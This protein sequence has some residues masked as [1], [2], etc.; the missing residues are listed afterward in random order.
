[1]GQWGCRACCS[2]VDTGHVLQREDSGLVKRCMEYEYN[3]VPHNVLMV[4]AVCRCV[5]VVGSWMVAC[6][7]CQSRTLTVEWVSREWCQSCKAK[8]PTT[9]L[10]CLLHSSC[11]YRRCM[12]HPLCFLSHL[13]VYT[14]LNV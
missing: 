7:S 12:I 5:G 3:D 11:Q 14:C 6:R 9:I 2:G 8:C 1:M 10:I 4:T 13:R